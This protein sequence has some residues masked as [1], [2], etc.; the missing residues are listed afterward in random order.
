MFPIVLKV[1]QIVQTELTK[2]L[3]SLRALILKS[4]TV[5]S[6]FLQTKIIWSWYYLQMNTVSL[7]KRIPAVT[8]ISVQYFLNIFIYIYQKHFRSLITASNMQ[9]TPTLTQV[10]FQIHFWTTLVLKN[11]IFPFHPR[12]G[13]M[14]LLYRS[15]YI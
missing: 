7:A 5:W 11:L 6:N 12:S 14:P 8:D 3:C 10:E 13:S 1:F 2:R 4:S 15:R 9:R